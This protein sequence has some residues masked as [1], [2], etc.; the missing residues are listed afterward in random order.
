M[1]AGPVGWREPGNKM[2][3]FDPLFE[4]FTQLLPGIITVWGQHYVES[5]K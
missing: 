1:S 5:H 3:E 4:D 2:V